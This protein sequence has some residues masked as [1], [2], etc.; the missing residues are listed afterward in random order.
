ML[1]VESNWEKFTKKAYDVIVEELALQVSKKYPDFFDTRLI[2]EALIEAEQKIS[3]I[4]HRSP[5]LTPEEKS[6]VTKA[7]LGQATG[8]GPLGKFFEETKESQ[9][10]TEVMVNAVENEPPRVFIGKAGGL[11]RVNEILFKTTAE[12]E[13]YMRTVAE[14]SGKAF[15]ED[16]PI[17]DAWLK[18]GSRVAIIGYKANPAGA[19]LTIRKSPLIRPALTMEN[20]IRFKM[21]PKFFKGFAK[22]LLV[23]GA[24]NLAV[25]GR[26]DSGKTTV[27]RALGLFIKPKE[28]VM[29]GETSYELAMPHLDNI[30]N[31][32]MVKHGDKEV[33]SMANICASFNRHNPDRTIVGEIRGGEIVDA[34][35]I[36]ESTS[37]GFWTTLHVSDVDDVRGRFPKMFQAGGVKLD[38]EDIDTQIR[39][40]CHF[41][42]FCDKDYTG[43]R[44]FTELVEV[45]KNGYRTIISFDKK[46]FAES[47][48]K[49][50]QWIYEN[51]VSEDRLN[52]LAFRGAKI[53]PE[54]KEVHQKILE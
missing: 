23:G 15:T 22:E 51:A 40:M 32:I 21:F 30:V 20:L 49:T 24:S 43:T 6:I 36:A 45:T 25:G 29:I 50:R 35:N 26:T 52:A 4:V 17:V 13:M 46:T 10:I 44:V 42:I 19:N 33:V 11:H 48:G 28:R 12:L 18:D 47:E 54:F 27:L 41:I 5:E 39:T 53:I 34:A 8:Y 37:G 14:N 7:I 38:R 1:K 9:K 2:G 16:T 3:E 31:V